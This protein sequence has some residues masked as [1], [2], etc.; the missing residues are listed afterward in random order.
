M[1]LNTI[2]NHVQKFKSFVFK[3]AQWANFEKTEIEILVEARANSRPICSQCGK[4]GPRHGR[5]PVR[6]FSYLPIWGIPVTMVYAP[7]R[8][9]CSWCGIRVESLPWT[10][11]ENPKSPLT[12][13]Y[14]WYLAGW[15]KRLSWSETAEVFKTTWDTVCQAVSMAVTW[16]L[17]HRNL[18]GI[19]SIGTDEIALRKGHSY[20]TLVYQIDGHCKRLLWIG[21]ER[22]IETLQGFFD[23]FG[24]EK[25]GL[26]RFI[27][28]D[29]WASYV[30]VIAERAP[31]AL[32]ILDR[33]HI[34]AHIGK[35][36]DEI[37]SEEV[38]ALRA[39][40]KQPLLSRAKWILL[41]RPEN[42][43]PNQEIRLGELL[44]HN[45]K[46]VRAYLLKEDFQSFWEYVSPAWADKFLNR[47]I[48]RVLRSRLKPMK[49]VALMLRSHQPLILNW[50]RARGQVSSGTV[51]G[52]NTKAKL[53]ARKS[54]GF[55]TF[56]I[57]EIALYHSLGALPVP[58]WTNKFS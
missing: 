36:I 22:T 10:L 52:F 51:E 41:K 19:V 15:S 18:S 5:Q 37:R 11:P 43:T 55:R 49:R 17:A 48:T 33:F 45:L 47:W 40:G 58:D 39:Q 38:R 16:G 35:A 12:E 53:T 8:V 50:F 34:M 26:L 32:H 9:D 44:S 3:K 28:S 1:L 46:A 56:K 30:K 24:P 21:K 20:I 57:Q 42:L 27:A 4:T 29:M 23:W 6:R 25:S 54:Y 7:R 13:T 31:Q 2:L 14:A